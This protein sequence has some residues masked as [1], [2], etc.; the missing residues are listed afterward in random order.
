MPSLKVVMPENELERR[1]RLE[2]RAEELRLLEAMLFASAEPLDE[3]EL[4]ARLPQ[5]VDVRAALA[6]LQEDYA[7]RGVNLVRIGGK[8][9]FRTAER[10]VLA[11]QQGDGRDAQ[12]LARRHRDARDH[13]L[14][15]AGDAHRDRGHPR[16]HD[17]QGLGRRAA[18][19]R[20]DP[21]ARAAQGARPA[22]DLRHQRGLPVAFR[23]RCARRS[24]GARGAEGL[25][26]A[27]RAA[28][29]RLLGADSV[30]RP[31]ACARTRIRWSRAISISAWRRRPERITEE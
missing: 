13:R 8:W 27:R 23:A 30:G 19:D 31:G 25:R 9:T 2:P 22:G 15:P 29:A 10:S 17:L 1:A 11:A 14:S 21:P 12:A 18:A 4:A 28:A 7:P 6:R 20:M 26:A 16:G 24:A 5:G 3:K